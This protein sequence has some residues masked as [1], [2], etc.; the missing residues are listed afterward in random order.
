MTQWWLFLSFPSEEK[1]RLANVSCYLILH[2][3]VFHIPT[4]LLMN[5]E[6]NSIGSQ[7]QG[8]RATVKNKQ[9]LDSC[10]RIFRNFCKCIKSRV[11]ID[12]YYLGRS[13]EA[14]MLPQVYSLGS[15]APQLYLWC[16]T[17]RELSVPDR[18]NFE[19]WQVSSENS[20]TER[21]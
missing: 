2:Y 19:I 7:T 20:H 9:I 1:S 11:F 3:I 10:T 12:V 4:N 8:P 18:R 16:G 5:W 14:G 13:Q 17:I 15:G 21:T 6:A